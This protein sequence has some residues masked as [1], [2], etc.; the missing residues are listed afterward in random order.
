MR[1]ALGKVIKQHII[2][3][4]FNISHLY[5]TLILQMTLLWI[6]LAGTA[7]ACS[8]GVSDQS[9]NYDDFS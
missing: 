7:A 4:Y 2:N 5:M 3:S 6:L 1:S 8:S 9:D